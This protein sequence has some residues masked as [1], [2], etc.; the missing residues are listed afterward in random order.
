M[1]ITD[2]PQ[3]E[4]PREKLLKHGPKQLTDAELLAIFIR[5]GVQGRTA[6][7]IARQ[8]LQRFG[9]LRQL[10]NAPITDYQYVPG[11]GPAKFA[12]LQAGLELGR[13]HLAESMQ[14][15]T[16]LSDPSAAHLFLRS[17]LRDHPHEVFAALFL[18]NQ[19]RLIEF[20]P[21]FHGTNSHTTVYPREL[22]RKAL[23]VNASALIVAHNH[24]SGDAE[25]SDQDRTM[26]QHL[27]EALSVVG[28]R[29]VDHIVIGDNQCV[30]FAHRGWL[31]ANYA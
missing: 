12:L 14:P 13:R 21:M 22:I 29:L 4:R 17:E 15:G 20:Q 7:D 3:D 18:D 1:A 28:I 8:L 19:C 24:P 26:T 31:N 5:T 16:Q 23:S 9:G 10:L 11:L 6:L 27:Y 25:P 2:W 30:S